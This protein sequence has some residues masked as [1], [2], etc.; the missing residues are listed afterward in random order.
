MGFIIRVSW[1]LLLRGVLTLLYPMN[2]GLPFFS[3]YYILTQSQQFVPIGYLSLDTRHAGTFDSIVARYRGRPNLRTKSL[4]GF[5]QAVEDQGQR[6]CRM[7]HIAAGRSHGNTENSP[8]C[9]CEPAIDREDLHVE[10]GA[11]KCDR[12]ATGQDAPF[13]TKD[14]ACASG[15]TGRVPPPNGA[16][17]CAGLFRF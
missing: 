6:K 16:R 4:E 9:I 17:W 12:R 2:A 1:R 3:F 11:S 14:I 7:D 10:V 13:N 5:K 15:E 8:R